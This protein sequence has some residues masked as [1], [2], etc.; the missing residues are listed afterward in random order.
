MREKL[1]PS[2]WAKELSGEKLS[3]RISRHLSL[4]RAHGLIKKLPNQRKHILTEK[5]ENYYG[6]KMLLWLLFQ[7]AS[8]QQKRSYSKG[9][10]ETDP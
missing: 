3:A 4:L 6:F 2:Q 9:I 10:A 1:E 7:C 8:A 5:R